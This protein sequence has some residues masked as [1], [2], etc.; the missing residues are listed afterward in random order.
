M[1]LY[2]RRVVGWAL[3]KRMTQRL[4]V[5]ALMMALL[6]RRPGPGL[7]VHSDRGSQYASG[8]YRKLLK[9]RRFVQ[10]MCRKG[11]C[12]D[13]APVESFFATLKL[14]LIY[15]RRYGSRQ[16]AKSD[17]FEW[18]AVFYNQKRMHSKLDYQSPACYE[19]Q[20]AALAA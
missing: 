19:A 17:I 8:G 4:A 16:E 2:S 10:S 12:W 9:I 15:H 11:D 7:I 20:T 5:D 18:I 3:R 13:N 1:D 6:Q 14:E